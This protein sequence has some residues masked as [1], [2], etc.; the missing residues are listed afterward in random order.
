MPCTDLADTTVYHA[1]SNRQFLPTFTPAPTVL[2]RQLVEVGHGIVTDDGDVRAL[3]LA[4][5]SQ[6]VS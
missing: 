6:K 3:P 2:A 4:C 5:C 1:L